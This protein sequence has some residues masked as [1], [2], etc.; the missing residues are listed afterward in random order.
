MN[1]EVKT[2]L[3]AEDD[4]NDVELTL[5]ALEEHNL[6]NKVAVVHDGEE[7]L[8]YLY[9][10]GKFK[11]CVN[12]NPIF[13][14]LDLK[15]P[16]LNGIEVL[17]QMK[18]DEKLK[19]IPIIVLSSSREAP[20]LAECYQLGV[21]AYVVKPVDFH[22]FIKAVKELGVFWAAIN[23]PPPNHVLRKGSTSNE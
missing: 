15:M 23:E 21:N 14:L 7:A 10:R 11:A 17:R 16:K 22:D 13:M 6:A 5:R 20:D 1:A 12:G 19:M 2:I 4:P 9:R 18:A 8:D 3:L